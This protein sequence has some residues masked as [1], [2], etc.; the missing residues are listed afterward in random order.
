MKDTHFAKQHNSHTAAFSLTDLCTQL[1]KQTFNVAPLDV[2]T[3][4]SGK[5]ELKRALVFSLHLGDGTEIWYLLQADA[6]DVAH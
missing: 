5:N 1:F 2:G 4:G 6:G 3:G